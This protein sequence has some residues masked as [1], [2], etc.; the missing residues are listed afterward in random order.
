[1]ITNKNNSFTRNQQTGEADTVAVPRQRASFRE[2][3]PLPGGP[4]AQHGALQEEVRQAGDRNRGGKVHFSDAS[5]RCEG[6]G[7][8]EDAEEGKA[9]N[10]REVEEGEALREGGQPGQVIC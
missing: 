7:R 1:M 9:G 10:F 4:R 2:E 5:G 3:P 8:E 6:H